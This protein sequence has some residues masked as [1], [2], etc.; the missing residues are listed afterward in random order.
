VIAYSFL[1]V[2]LLL[3][4]LLKTKRFIQLKI[5]SR[6]AFIKLK[7][8]YFVPTLFL[9]NGSIILSELR[10]FFSYALQHKYSYLLGVICLF[11]TNLLAV[12]IPVYLGESIDLLGG[13]DD[14]DYHALIEKIYWVIGFAFCVMISR[15]ASRMLFFNPGDRKSV[16]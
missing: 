13:S 12:T 6:D 2:I 9:S 16:V 8:V 7:R 4:T 14:Q 5:P 11:I 3:F 15:T 1:G 10:L